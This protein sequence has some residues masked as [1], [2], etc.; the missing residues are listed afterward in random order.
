MSK[1]IALGSLAGLFIGAV[2]AIV[3]AAWLMFFR[4]L[5]F[6]V[7][8]EWLL[9]LESFGAYLFLGALGGGV[10]GALLGLLDRARGRT[11][12]RED[13]LIHTASVILGLF[14]MVGLTIY[15]FSKGLPEE[16]EL[17]SPAGL[18]TLALT[19]VFSVIAAF[20]AS[21][22]AKRVFGASIARAARSPASIASRIAIVLAPILILVGLQYIRTGDKR[23]A[24]AGDITPVATP[25]EGS[26]NVILITLDTVRAENL[27]LYGYERKTA[28]HLTELA[29]SSVVY[30]NAYSQASWT[31]PSHGSI[32]TGLHPSELSDSWGSKGIGSGHITLAE[33]LEKSGYRTAGV[34]G[35]PFCSSAFGLAQGFDYYEDQLPTK[36]TP[37][38][39]QVI[40]RLYPNLFAQPGKRRADRNNEFVFRWLDRNS[41]GPFFLFINY[42]DAHANTNPIYPYRRA[43]DGGFNPIRALPMQ[44]GAM[45]ASVTEGA[46]DL[47]DA[48]KNHWVTMYDCEI[49][50]LDSELQRLFSKLKRLGV[51]DNSL[52]VITSDHGHS[53]G[54]HH[55]AGHGGWLF[56]E[57]VRIPLLVRYPQGEH[58]GT[59]VPDRVGHVEILPMIL[60]EL[61][62][63]PP[64]SLVPPA[65]DGDKLCVLENGREWP[66]HWRY[67]YSDRDLRALYRGSYKLVTLDGE[68]S[69]LY[70]LA[71]DPRE[72]VNLI[73]SRRTLADSLESALD[74]FAERLRPPPPETRE[75]DEELLKQL[76]SVGYM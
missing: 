51:Y 56:E 39:A 73:D 4:T 54:E 68:A 21:V 37:S 49:L 36:S 1:A 16:V 47:S 67:R 41:S 52:I 66:H 71:S 8:N 14:L 50:F 57:S 58:G 13:T 62:M 31:L 72:L 43:F 28:P 53:Y 45:E 40:N 44:Q 60:K 29:A 11:S 59:V 3:E 70:D 35:G 38:L 42:Y 55:L 19:A 10:V 20:S 48:E 12:S 33:I 63:Q 75:L 9:L 61:G 65:G 15:M 26:P 46:R 74:D 64:D 30:E 27:D 32:F 23:R 25:R 6:G 69:E 18:V 76:K 34:I 7:L 22:V 24:L 5:S 17:G 2:G